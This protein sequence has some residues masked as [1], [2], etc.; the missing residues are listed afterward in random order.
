[1]TKLSKILCLSHYFAYILCY[2][3]WRNDMGSILFNLSEYGQHEEHSVIFYNVIWMHQNY[4]DTRFKIVISEISITCFV[5]LSKA[6]N[7]LDAYA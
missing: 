2:V 1:M 6:V 3:C 7:R 5:C 4:F